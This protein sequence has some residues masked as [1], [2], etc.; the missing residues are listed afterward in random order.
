MS[1]VNIEMNMQS[2]ANRLNTD[3]DKQRYLK[4]KR[5]S[6]KSNSSKGQSSGVSSGSNYGSE[7]MLGNSK[8]E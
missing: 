3:E 4:D 7:D 5:Q 8:N 6:M 1:K 2:Q